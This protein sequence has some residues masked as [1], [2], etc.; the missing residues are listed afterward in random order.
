MY[1]VDVDVR[2]GTIYLPGQSIYLHCEVQDADG[3]PT[4]SFGTYTVYFYAVHYQSNSEYQLGS[5]VRTPAP[6]SDRDLFDITGAFPEDVPERYYA[7][8]AEVVY[9]EG[10]EQRKNRWW[11]SRTVRVLIPSPNLA[12]QSV[13]AMDGYYRPGDEIAVNVIVKNFGEL[14]SGGFSIDCSAGK[15]AGTLTGGFGIGSA[16]SGAVGPG[17]QSTVSFTGT[18]PTAISAG[19]YYIQA[20]VA[21]GGDD[22]LRNNTGY[23]PIRI[24]VGPFADLTIQSVDVTPGTY[25]PGDTMV[26][27]A[28]LKNAG[29]SVS[30]AYTVRY[31]VSAD[32]GVTAYD[33]TIGSADCAGLACGQQQSLTTICQLPSYLPKGSCYIGAIV[34]CPRE[35]NPRNNVAFD[36]EAVELVHPAEYVCGQASYD[37]TS[38]WNHPIRYA[39]AKIYD[40]NGSADLTDDCTIGETYTDAEGNYGVRLTSNGASHPDI[41]VRVFT[42]G[43]SGACP[44]TTSKISRREGPRARAA[45]QHPQH[46][47]SVSIH[48]IGYH[49]GVV[50]P[51]VDRGR[52]P[53][54]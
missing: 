34:T 3:R 35:A 48:R 26:V 19:E 47:L 50:A 52:V 18:L 33:Y 17:Q 37:D 39:L 5:T 46:Q 42:E 36:N 12:V 32:A 22:D 21:C 51:Y 13:D 49:S 54:V 23:D 38:G 8:T 53:G 43:V 44:G 1:I 4:D 15:D 40:T 25:R 14:D 9:T 45:L 24:A 2:G 16:A 41:Y 31:Y 30:P 7:V 10:G 28:L 20:V 6:G 29:E 27:R 11:T